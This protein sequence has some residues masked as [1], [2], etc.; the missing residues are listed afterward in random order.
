MDF[1]GDRDPLET[2]DKAWQARVRFKATAEFVEL[3][4]GF[5][6]RLAETAFAPKDYQYGEWNVPGEWIWQ[7]I[8]VY[9]RFPLMERLNQV[10]D[11]I[12]SRL[13][14]EF[15]RDEGRAPPEHHPPGPAEDAAL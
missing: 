6:A 1:V 7:R 9:Q 13:E 15:F 2:S 3:M 14:N 8:Q 11:D 5:I 12:H 4:D 10:A